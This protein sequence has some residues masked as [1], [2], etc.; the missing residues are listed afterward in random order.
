MG[1]ES[2]AEHSGDT[3][4]K[5]PGTTLSLHHRTSPVR[6]R[7][8][9]QAASPAPQAPGHHF[10]N[11]SH[12]TFWNLDKIIAV[13][14]TLIRMDSAC[15]LLLS[16]TGFSSKTMCGHIVGVWHPRPV[17]MESRKPHTWLFQ[18]WALSHKG[19]PPHRSWFPGGQPQRGASNARRFVCIS[20]SRDD[21]LIPTTVP[22]R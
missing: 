6:T 11:H 8:L 21:N 22:R 10:R 14:V 9:L 20:F 3:E 12:R 7:V 19:N 5:Q 13:A 16:V 18:T 4:G 2:L 15:S 17:L 1:I